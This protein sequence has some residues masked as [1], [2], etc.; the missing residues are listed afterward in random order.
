MGRTAKNG[1]DASGF[2]LPLQ[3]QFGR[4]RK[5]GLLQGMTHPAMSAESA[6]Q[7]SP[8]WKSTRSGLWNPGYGTRAEESPERAA[9]RHYVHRYM[10]LESAKEDIKM[11]VD[12]I[13]E[14]QEAPDCRSLCCRIY[15]LTV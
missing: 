1:F 7:Q 9:Q 8:G 4:S 10:I 6:G 2:G 11:R 14:K 15:N 12:L 13:C 3:Q 5:S